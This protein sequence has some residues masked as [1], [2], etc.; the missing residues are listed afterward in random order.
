[1][2]LGFRPFQAALLCLIA[3]T[4]PVAWGGIGTPL[5]TLSAVTGLDVEALSAT[6]GRI[7]PLLSVVIPFWLVRTMTGWRNT[8]R[9]LATAAGHRGN[10]RRR[11]VSLVESGGFRAGGYRRLGL[12]HV[13]RS[14]RDATLEAARVWRS[15]TRRKAY[16]ATGLTCPS[17]AIQ[18]PRSGPAA[19]VAACAGLDALRVADAHGACLGSSGHQVLG[20][21]RGQRLAG[22][23]ALLEAGRFPGCI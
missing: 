5:R 2:G 7:L 13:G 22:C 6:C 1:M 19:P 10:F 3:N 16:G 8:L 11:S 14:A 15:I 12:E 18:R 23:T 17:S 9:S 21:S 4:A 20:N